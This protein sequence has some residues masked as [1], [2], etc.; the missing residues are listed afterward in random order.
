MPRAT[1]PP[2]AAVRFRGTPASLSAFATGIDQEQTLS[3]SFT[4]GTSAKKAEVIEATVQTDFDPRILYLE[5][6]Q[7]VPP[8]AYD[9]KLTVDGRDRPARVEVDPA[10]LLRVVPEQLRME[11][12]AGDMVGVDLTILNQGNTTLDLRRVNAVGIFMSGGI[13]RALRRAY[14]TKLRKDQRRVDVIADSLAEA[15]GGLLKIRIEKGGGNLG[16]GEVRELRL[17]LYVPSELAPASEYSGNWEMPGLVYPIIIQVGGEAV[18]APEEPPEKPSEPAPDVPRV[19]G[20]AKRP[21]S[22]GDS[23]RDNTDDVPR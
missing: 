7:H 1:T 11:A 4:V 8:G 16:P 2:P 19:K 21:K 23:P 17:V 9:G 18:P 12:Q 6:P 10:P 22:G 14:V 13:E 3:V 20:F 5:L 15:H